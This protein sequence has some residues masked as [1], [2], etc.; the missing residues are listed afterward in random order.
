MQKPTSKTQYLLR[1]WQI[2]ELLRNDH[3]LKLIRSS[4]NAFQNSSK[5][6]SKIDILILNILWISTGQGITKMILKK[7]N[8]VGEIPLL[9]AYRASAVIKTAWYWQ[10]GGEQVDGPKY[11]S[12]N[13][14]TEIHAN[15]FS[16]GAQAI[17]WKK[18]SLFNKWCWSNWLSIVKTNSHFY[19]DF[20]I[21]HT[22][23]NSQWILD[24]KVKYKTIKCLG[25]IIAENLWIQA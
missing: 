9:M 6:D 3:L 8:K 18:D 16:Q 20:I 23:V 25:K 15:D 7:E 12:Q 19:L 22:K 13:K 2:I 17:H 24:L 11:R 1:L 5:E 10:R 21:P 4:C 14:P